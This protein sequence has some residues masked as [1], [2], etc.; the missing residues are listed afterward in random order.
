MGCMVIYSQLEGI[1]NVALLMSLMVHTETYLQACF[2]LTTLQIEY[3]LVIQPQV[4]H[5][6]FQLFQ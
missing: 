4:I 6:I 1:S 5:E 3:N 2:S